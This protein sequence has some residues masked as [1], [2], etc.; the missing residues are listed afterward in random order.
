MNKTALSTSGGPATHRA[1]KS[2]SRDLKWLNERT[3]PLASMVLVLAVLGLYGYIVH[4]KVPLS[5]FSPGII[6]GL[7]ALFVF[8]LLAITLIVAMILSPALFLYSELPKVRVPSRKKRL[9]LATKRSRFQSITGRAKL[10][11]QKHPF[12][13]IWSMASLLS[14]VIWLAT[15]Y[16]LL[17]LEP[18]SEDGT[19]ITTSGLLLVFATF[20]LTTLVAIIFRTRKSITHAFFISLFSSLFQILTFFIFTLPALA[21][22]ESSIQQGPNDQRISLI[23]TF[24]IALILTQILGAIFIGT[25]SKNK[26]PIATSTFAALALMT[27][28]HTILQPVGSALTANALQISAS[29]AR[30]CAIFGLNTQPFVL[31]DIRATPITSIPLKILTEA[32]SQYVVRPHGASSKKTY[33]VPTEAVAWIDDCSPPNPGEKDDGSEGEPG[34]KKDKTDHQPQEQDR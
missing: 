5:L 13:L 17:A 22:S 34:E 19:R 15:V 8:Q 11:F 28:S 10:L 9:L 16:K 20:F 14:C 25:L 7:P 12:A 6:T 1:I 24:F 23:S 27:L 4:E 26:Q 18:N 21:I 2:I 3:W 31:D 30:A 29:G 32:D 33:F